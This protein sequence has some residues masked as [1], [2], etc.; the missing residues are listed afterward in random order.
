MVSE[1]M[2]TMRL[3]KCFVV[4]ALSLAVTTIYAQARTDPAPGSVAEPPH[5]DAP[6][7]PK[8]IESYWT[9]EQMDQAQPMPTPTVI[10]DSNAPGT[11]PC[12]DAPGHESAPGGTPGS[13]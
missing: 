2:E 4:L 5:P 7:D 9:K 6:V 8:D 3:L 11:P 1:V 10:I 13:R 12:R